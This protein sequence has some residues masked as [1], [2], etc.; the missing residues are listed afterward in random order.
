[1]YLMDT[2]TFLWYLDDSPH[3]SQKAREIICGEKCLFLSLTSLWEIA[4]KKTIHKLD[5]E[6]STAD[7]I[8]ICEEDGI[9][10][11]P[12]ESRYFDTIQI[13][14]Y[15]HGD[16]FD[17]LIMA[18]ARDNDLTLLTDDKNIQKYNEIK[19]MW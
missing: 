19:Q 9:T 6:E 1:M 12:I 10:I 7:L 13:L 4:I 3:L 5:L 11:L 16:P 18:T 17:R 14:P 15:I 2:C 8:K